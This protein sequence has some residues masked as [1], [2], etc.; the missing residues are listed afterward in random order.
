MK[1]R[2]TL[3]PLAGLTAAVGAVSCGNE[4]KAP[5]QR[6][7]IIYIMSD[8][9]S[10]QTMG[11]YGS[12]YQ[13]TPNIDRLAGEGVVFNNSFVTNSI[14][15]PSRAVL[16]TGKHSHL[17]GKT[18]NDQKFD[19]SQQTLPKLMQQAGYR[20]AIV[21]KWH[22]DSEPT[23]FDYWEIVPGQ[24]DYYNPAFIS[25]EGRARHEGYITDIITDKA[26]DWIGS[27]RESGDPFC[28]F[29]HH[30]AVHRNWMSDSLHL[31]LYEDYDFALPDN[32]YDDYEGRQ[33]AALHEM[34]IDRHMDIVYDL[35]MLHDSLDTYY[36]NGYRKSI[37]GRMNE[38]QK[39]VWDRHYGPII[40]DL[41]SRNLQGRE[42]AEW[43][44]QR[45]MRDYLKTVRSLDDNIGRL[46]EYLRNEGLLENTLVVYASD[47]G[48]YMGEHGWFDKR[49]MY[50][51]SL[52]TPLVMRLPD[53]YPRRGNIEQMVQNLD[54]APTFLEMA[55]ADVPDDMQGV[56]LVP[57]L[58]GK[59]PARWRSALYYHYYEYPG[60][61][62]VRRH[63]GVRTDRY[64]L[65]RFYGDIDAWELY[66]LREDPSEMH[67]IYG[68]PGTERITAKLKHELHD[69]QEQYQDPIANEVI[70]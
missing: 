7:N 60:I 23:G 66:D 63:F 37:Y 32:F 56:S 69:L 30:K 41:M 15:G 52:R 21:G 14:S 43:K 20:T 44:Y 19:G 9:H 47:Q 49:F 1:T 59:N 58:K 8:D 17:N 45:Y 61:H 65:I 36:S 34:G 67:N 11:C 16:M 48:F 64:K 27:E 54:Y 4:E 31:D 40:E 22:L 39:E 53:G 26:I 38:N 6:P 12:P 2:T 25:P 55:G 57:L 50:E 10:Y 5:A 70:N 33:A 42:L 29:V 46:M 13:A 62:A 24:G 68:Q 3:L 51:E 28:I 18:D 35:K